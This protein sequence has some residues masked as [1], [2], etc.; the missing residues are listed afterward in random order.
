MSQSI[1]VRIAGANS[2]ASVGEIR[3]I[4]EQPFSRDSAGEV[5]TAIRRIPA[6]EAQ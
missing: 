6:H 4:V 5:I 1:A 2:F 3:E